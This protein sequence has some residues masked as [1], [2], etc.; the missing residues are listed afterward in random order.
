MR[1]KSLL[2]IIGCLLWVGAVQ[3]QQDFDSLSKKFDWYRSHALQEKI[4][5]HI[6][7]TSYLTGE[8]LWFKLYYVDGSFHKALDI[9]KVAYVEI[10]DKSN[11]AV[12]QTKVKLKNGGGSGSLFIPAVLN[13]GNYVFR[14]YT[15][16]MKNFSPDFYF[17]Q[18]ITIVNPFIKIEEGVSDIKKRGYDVQFF[19]EGG[20]A[21]A[22]IQNKIGFRAT[23]SSG[24]GINFSG[25]VVNS[26]G[27]PIIAFHPLR[28]GNGHFMMIPKADEK[29][30]V[31]I[32]DEKGSVSQYP[33]PEVRNS[34]YV[35]SLKDNGANITID[36]EASG[37]NMPLVYLFAHTR[38]VIIKS[39][40]KYLNEKKASFTINK[41]ELGEGVTHLTIFD[42]EFRP[43]CER[44]FFKRPEQ[45]LYVTIQSTKASY[46]KRELVQ[47]SV[48]TNVDSDVSISVYQKDSIP[49][50]KRQNAF[51]YLWLTS[52]LKGVIENPEYYF[53]NTDSA[54]NVA[55]D[56]L[57]LTHGWRR[58]NWYDI[59]GFKSDYKY[60]PEYR[61]HFVY[62][63]ITNSD[64]TPVS[65]VL[66]SLSSPNELINFYGSRSNDSGEIC[67]EVKNLTDERK[68]FVHQIPIV[69]STYHIK[70]ENPF[71]TQHALV[72]FPPFKLS[73]SLAK[74]ILNRSV[75]M[76]VQDIYAREQIN[77]FKKL[78]S[79]SLQFYGKADKA[80][81]L[82]DYV[83]FPLLE[84]VLRE[85]VSSVFVRKRNNKF[86]F[87]LLDHIN[88]S[89]IMREDPLVL[90]DGV[91]VQDVN[92]LMGINALKIKKIEVVG[93]E[94]H[95]G[96][97]VFSGVLSFFTY[98][99]DMGNF[100][101]NDKNLSLNYDG[102]QSQ[103]EFYSP[104]YETNEARNS[105][106]PD[107]RTLLYWNP[108]L[109]IEKEKTSNIQF[110]TSDLM[111]EFEVVIEGVSKDGV[112]GNSTYSFSVEK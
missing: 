35:M 71:S 23:D 67:F 28:F 84:E 46:V 86:H 111:G 31:I 85:Y 41:N 66:T 14:V 99:S 13:S 79:D 108:T 101:S 9:S 103:R 43:V 37:T 38:Q 25:V 48:N 83:R 102:L 39:E 92:K 10:V 72:S 36:I 98:N 8:L 16:W 59:L 51:E 2:Y 100:E 40:G 75:A 82:D 107:H 45:K 42:H 90:L 54:A 21:I 20:Y 78:S 50:H 74:P 55:L 3:A 61:T 34:G 77:Q 91:P 93:R 95:W 65:G 1:L 30:R 12:V 5:A 68:I 89:T 15:N 87:M 17:H 105:R 26:A 53:E 22:G 80:Y 64:D 63:K 73:S 18:S 94:Y 33:F 29:Y 11:E 97:F 62:G 19:P 57:M 27:E 4:Y 112:A 32:K 24:K 6:D 81:F 110:Y 70:I 76:Q 56:N 88:N 7:R 44:L 104:L 109:I 106:V 49:S 96:P 69:D 52:D 60:V 47:L 58:F